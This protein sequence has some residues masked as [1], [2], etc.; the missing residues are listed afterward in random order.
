MI[1]DPTIKTSVQKVSDYLQGVY[2][3]VPQ[4]LIKMILNIYQAF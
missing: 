1:S 3:H 4:S 2:Y